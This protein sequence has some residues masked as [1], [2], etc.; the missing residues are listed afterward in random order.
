MLFAVAARDAAI[1]RI[2]AAARTAAKG[3]DSIDIPELCLRNLSALLPQDHRGVALDV[4]PQISE[5]GSVLMHIHPTVSDV[6]DQQ[7]E[8]S[9]RGQ[10]D[11]LP[12]TLSQ[13]RESDSIVKA[14]S[15][16]IIVIG[17]LMRES[18]RRQDYKMP[19]LG[20]VPGV[21]RDDTAPTPFARLHHD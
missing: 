20:D 1:Q 10:T 9:V 7:K 21:G 18:R 17:G 15:G 11:S 8:L 12:L 3:F 19:L 16:Q 5:T 2:S 6:I 13:I 4:T 14:H